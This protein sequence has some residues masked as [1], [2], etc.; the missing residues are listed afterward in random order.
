MP[1][2][3]DIGGVKATAT[4]TSF[5]P[6]LTVRVR[7]IAR[8]W[9]LLSLGFVLMIF[10]GEAIAADA[11]PGFTGRD[12]ILMSFFPVGVL[13]GLILGWW[14]EGLGGGLTLASL[15]AFYLAL[16]LMDGRWPGGP[17]FAL[18][19]APGL[20]FLVCRLRSRSADR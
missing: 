10:V 17:Y 15:I 20:L 1:V 5:S 8:I 4:D 9:S 3:D 6:N 2:L 14:K 16:W 13:A 11:G 12:L 18:V 19:A 7:W